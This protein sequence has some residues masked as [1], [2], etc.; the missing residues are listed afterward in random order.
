MVVVVSS[1]PPRHSV[2]MVVLVVVA[3]VVTWW[4]CR[5]YCHVTMVVTRCDGVVV[6]ATSRCGGGRGVWWC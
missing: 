5:R 1:L 6:P 4:W 3:V 2:V